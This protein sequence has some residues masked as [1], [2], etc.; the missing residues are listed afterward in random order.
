M[1]I[2]KYDLD[3][4]FKV[5]LIGEHFIKQSQVFATILNSDF[6]GNKFKFNFDNKD[7]NKS[8]KDLCKLVFRLNQTIKGGILM[9]FTSYTHITDCHK[10]FLESKIDFGNT[11]IFIEDKDPLIA[12]KNYE[13]YRKQVRECSKGIFMC[14]S[15][16]KLSEGLNFEN[17]MARACLIIGIP[18]LLVNDARVNLKKAYLDDCLERYNQIQNG[19]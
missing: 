12:T 13:S 19:A 18:Y 15:R 4:D 11:K 5:Q 6:Q 16:G 7:L 2:L 1:K 10:Q 3:S 8:Y 17:S 14:V 9:F